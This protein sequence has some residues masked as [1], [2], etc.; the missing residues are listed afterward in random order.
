M[1]KRL[2]IFVV[3]CTLVLTLL[4][5]CDMKNAGPLKSITHPYIAQYECV[6]A[7]LGDEDL[8]D[9]FDYIKIT[10]VNNDTLELNYKLKDGDNKTIESNY[11]F[12]LN[13]RTLTA[14]VG[15]L[16][17]TVKQSTVIEKG[18]FTISKS[19]GG[20]QLIMKFKAT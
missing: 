1:K 3:L 16:G 15:I 6:E 13:S 5:A 20:K 14:E 11:N 17:Y 12:D 19:I 2:I 8:L 9:K 10:L 7:T 4:S 18:K